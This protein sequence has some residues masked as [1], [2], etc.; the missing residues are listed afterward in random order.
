MPEVTLRAYGREIDQLIEREKLEEAIAHCR[1]ILQTYPKH[2]ET[3]RLL[4]KAYLE[5]KRYGDAADIFQRVL[6][7][8]PDD[9]VA[10]I[11][12][13]IVREDEGNLD[14]AIWHMERAFETNPSNPAI[15]QEMKRLIGRRD[16]LEP[17]KVRL[18]RG[19]LARMYAHGELFPQAIAELRSALQEDP[20][21]PDLQV[22]LAE[23]YWRTEQRDEAT[24]IAN[25]VLT[26]LP[27]CMEA[28]RIL[29]ANLQARD[30]VEEAALY[31]RRLAGLDP[32]AAFVESAMV[33]P[34]TIEETAVSVE[35][36]DW[37]PGGAL[38]E[39]GPVQ[40]GWAATLGME[41]R[42]D[43]ERDQGD[44]PEL[45]Q[46]GPLPSWLEPGEPPPFEA[47]GVEDEAASES[48]QEAKE[49]AESA[50]PEWLTEET[51]SLEETEEPVPG[52]SEDEFM[53]ELSEA[54]DIQPET[55]EAKG[56]D[57][58]SE[59]PD[60]MQEA[61]WSE[62]TGEAVDAPVSFSDAELRSLEAG[63][64]PADQP[65]AE[66][67]DGELAP[68]ELPD[69][70]RNIAP[71]DEQPAVGRPDWIPETDDDL[72]SDEAEGFPIDP[73]TDVPS[74]EQE[75]E[76]E[77]QEDEPAPSFPSAVSDVRD[78][79]TW[80][81]EDAP[82]ATDT[83]VT[84]LGS[85]GQDA[86]REDQETGD[87]PEW[88]KDTGPLADAGD[89]GIGLAVPTTDSEPADE[90]PG[91]VPDWM[92]EAPEREQPEPE[93]EAEADADGEL[94]PSE[95]PGWLSAVAEAAADEGSEQAPTGVVDDL[96]DWS[97]LLSEP[98]EGPDQQPH[99]IDESDEAA[100][101]P[102]ND[103]ASF[104]EEWEALPD[105]R[106]DDA[107]AAYSAEAPAEVDAEEG[108]LA[109]SEP[110]EWLS[111]VV[112]QPPTSVDSDQLL[113]E[114]TTE[115]EP[116]DRG[117]PPDWMQEESEQTEDWLGEDAEAAAEAVGDTPDWLRGL[118][119]EGAE[120]SAS[121][122]AA[123]APDWLRQIAEPDLEPVEESEEAA[124]A[125]AEPEAPVPEPE[126]EEP[127]SGSQVADQFE[128]AAAQMETPPHGFA[129][130]DWLQG[131][132]G[133]EV[134][135]A[136]VE[137]SA[138][139]SPQP[140][141]DGVEVEEGATDWVPA[142]SDETEA[143]PIQDS[144]PDW[145]QGVDEELAAEPID[146]GAPD[147]LKGIGEQPERATPS[148]GAADWLGDIG[149]QVSEPAVEIEPEPV[150]EPIE[151][152]APEAPTAGGTAPADVDDEVISWLEDL[153][154]AQE[155]TQ[156]PDSVQQAAQTEAGTPVMEQR[157]IPDEPQEGL[158]W[159]EQLAEQR[160]LDVDVSLPPSA[161]T[162]KPA[163]R[164]AAAEQ[165]AKAEVPSAEDSAPDWL[166]RM[167]TQPLP[168]ID[169]EGTEA[170]T[171]EAGEPEAITEPPIDPGAV[172]IR[173]RPEELRAE[174]A[175]L[176]AASMEPAEPTIQPQAAAPPTD[177]QPIAAAGT[178]RD[179]GADEEPA[180]E[181]E[182]PE[183]LMR[184]ADQKPEAPSA[185]QP[186]MPPSPAEAAPQ[187]PAPPNE[188]E[189]MEPVAPVEAAPPTEAVPVQPA[190]P[191]ESEPAAIAPP[192]EAVPMQPAAPAEAEP[193]APAPPT[194]AVPMQPAAPSEAAPAAPAPPTEA[195][196]VQPA[197]PAEAAPAAP[198]PP[199]EAVPPA[200]PTT[201][202][203]EPTRA[204]AAETEPSATPS[205]AE[206]I[207][208]QEPAP[209]AA[210]GKP[211]KELTLEQSRQ[212][213]ASGELDEAIQLY[214][215]LIKRKQLLDEVIEDLRMA[216][217]R[218]PDDPALWQTLGDAYMKNDQS[219]EAIDAYRKGMEV[220]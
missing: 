72:E 16:G 75:A 112:S 94:T 150:P 53:S 58:S 69:W 78:L 209:A 124:A 214:G 161:T 65:S 163:Q 105:S 189:A 28:N 122:R 102:A 12:M 85:Q 129:P 11:G 79:P 3:Y 192:T 104:A 15:Q 157:D 183:W 115:G 198:A 117:E 39:S 208:A 18:T 212:A 123:D 166:T 30:R 77:P 201:P 74:L 88:M 171:G 165:P 179:A 142:A 87:L 63:Q 22:L 168:K 149:E 147:W 38:P 50:E 48:V 184:A 52:E 110:P 162:Q 84:W 111:E 193:A 155:Q 146:D 8:V 180:T 173:T 29:A 31:H 4:G 170:A 91:A 2:L 139:E 125:V 71:G 21:R 138:P 196:P 126:P 216:V 152:L 86:E 19:A 176:E 93:L 128:I 82:G 177:E 32:Y 107:M 191:A 66:A 35:R 143:E 13:A 206:A 99:E 80:I 186:P 46:T 61:G 158:E 45:P 167:A 26:K 6:S 89:A 181:D 33:D 1:H 210:R 215:G 10:H 57:G 151:Q 175:A 81:T 83:I 220:A 174:A 97:E 118:A 109:A 106:R 131:T 68:A 90:Q 51:E 5:A 164:A 103:L 114:M 120:E 9:F 24:S 172:T 116:A 92:D 148:G 154:A 76:L 108:E 119:E 55:A 141:D 190:A 194:E 200:E 44:K 98:A 96:D 14:A 37:Q 43:R 36:S 130:P 134:E 207:A 49:L 169:L 197:A 34:S 211:D 133:D 42:Q 70:V 217:D 202:P 135:L 187:P 182:L 205:P 160:G 17:H 67:D 204:P 195:V 59:I 178:G 7:A 213:L 136:A 203:A 27:Y 101:E 113:A 159:L 100:A 144:A 219:A 185:A 20:E 62:S 41:M 218:T 64:L 54:G 121:E 140:S 23:M 132:G 25:Q 156:I 145:L 137:E 127:A 47:T 73:P 56:G 153:A 60:W 95:L 40:P 199:A 188:P